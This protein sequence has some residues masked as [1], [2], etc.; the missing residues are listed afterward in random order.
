MTEVTENRTP[1]VFSAL[2][3]TFLDSR[4]DYNVHLGFGLHDSCFLQTVSCESRSIV[5]EKKDLHC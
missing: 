5:A 2:S 1:P 3:L 4:L